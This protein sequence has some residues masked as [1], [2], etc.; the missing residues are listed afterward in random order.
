[1]LELMASDNPG[2]KLILFPNHDEPCSIIV[3]KL[4]G[5][6]VN[7]IA[8]KTSKFVK[9]YISTALKTEGDIILI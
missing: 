5:C 4:N 6:S 3:N 1:M 8:P 9:N 7:M 2:A